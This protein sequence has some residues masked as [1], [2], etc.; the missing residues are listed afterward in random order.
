MRIGI[1]L[2]V[3]NTYEG[4]VWG[5]EVMAQ[6]L[7]RALS[8]CDGVTSAD[9]YDPV[10]VHDNLDVLLHFYPFPALRHVRGPKH[11]WWY[12]A[13][14]LKPLLENPD[15]TKTLS[16]YDGFF[17]ASPSLKSHLLTWSVPEHKISIMPM[18]CDLHTYRK[19]SPLDKYRHNVVFCGNGSN[20]RQG[21]I[22]RFLVPLKE[23]GLKIY[24][25]NWDHFPELMECVQGPI[26]PSE[27]PTLYSSAKV[28]I[29]THVFWHYDHDLPTSRL[30][31]ALAC[32]SVVVSDR[33]PFAETL[34]GNAVIWTDGYE[35]VKEK[36]SHLL[37]HGAELETHQGK[38]KKLIETH[39]SFQAYAPK[40]HRILI[41][42]LMEPFIPCGQPATALATGGHVPATSSDTSHADAASAADWIR[43]G[44]SAFAAGQSGVALDAFQRAVQ[45]D[46]FNHLAHNNMSVVRWHEGQLTDALCSLSRALELEANDRDIILNCGMM[47]HALGRAQD[48]RIILESFLARNPHDE[49][50]QSFLETLIPSLDNTMESPPSQPDSGT[51]SDFFFRHGKIRLSQGS[52]EHA[53]ACFEMALEEDPGHAGA[54][55]KLGFMCWRDGKI[56]EALTHYYHALEIDPDDPEVMLNGSRVLAKAGEL[57]TALD[58]L[59]LYLRRNPDDLNAWEEFERLSVNQGIVPWSPEDLSPEVAAIYTRDGKAL[60]GAGDDQGASEAFDR[61]A[62]ILK[63]L[64]QPKRHSITCIPLPQQG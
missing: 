63:R 13:P 12:Q 23:L 57:S 33:L 62:H 64:N 45:L 39:L 52:G 19:V 24:G 60:A 55:S 44:E 8:E 34:F 2:P 17:A 61:A 5:D 22:D 27:V 20:R 54:H 29:S 9:V 3:I 30:W 15:W 25:A 37:A 46:P 58:L 21:E 1:Q 7:A 36:V 47:F 50:V 51:A 56:E 10:T 16:H 14:T 38:G 32:E 43:R 31:E 53:R 6:G 48:A 28:V 59:R 40:L 49:A 35:D 26:H 18:S 41:S 11:Y 42:G 4:A